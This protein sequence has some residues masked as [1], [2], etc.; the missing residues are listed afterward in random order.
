MGSR[1]MS[2]AI[3]ALAVSAC[4]AGTPSGVPPSGQRTAT[5]GE[6]RQSSPI[7]FATRHP[8]EASPSISATPQVADPAAIT[9]VPTL[10]RGTDPAGMTII[11]ANLTPNDPVAD[12]ACADLLYSALA[13]IGAR[14][15]SVTRMAAGNL[16]DIIGCSCDVIAG[17]KD[18]HI[19]GFNSSGD[20]VPVE[21]SAWPWGVSA[22]FDSPSVLRAKL[23]VD[24]PAAIANRTALPYCGIVSPMSPG[25]PDPYPCFRGAVLTGHPAE[26]ATEAPGF[27]GG[28]YITIYRFTGS[29]AIA[30]YSSATDKT[31][32]GKEHWT[33]STGTMYVEPDGTWT[34]GPTP[35][36]K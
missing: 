18:G 11:C 15:S 23:G 3:A 16:K 22:A 26:M 1:W 29:G 30:A 17:F 2:I 27:E 8:D 31:T 35:A 33:S 10:P 4:S 32:A 5:P 13:K 28:W 34:L 21:A 9:P 14:A 19:E 7:V 20:A 36:P 25:A 24:P 12:R 6:T